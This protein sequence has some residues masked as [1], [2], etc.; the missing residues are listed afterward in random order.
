MRFGLRKLT[1]LDYPGCVAATVFTCGCNFRC[2]FCHNGSL[3]LGS[4]EN[5]EFEREELLDFLQKRRKVL[6]GVCFTGGEPLLHTETLDI[7]AA[8]KSL[9]YRIKL[10]TNG[11]LPGRL[12][13]AVSEGLVD[14]VAMD[15]KNS[16]GKYELTSGN[17]AVLDQ[18]CESV[19]FLLNSSIDYEFRTTV[20]KP[21]HCREDFQAIGGWLRGA[22][23]YFLQKFAP[24]PDILSADMDMEAPSQDEMQ[25]FLAEVQKFIP[26]A[27]IRGE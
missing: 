24:A 27:G 21:L 2:P 15:I 7:L 11:S 18:V 25:E 5:L 9:G 10:D 12:K 1:L 13:M 17:G 14:T 19:E 6:D 26:N 3:V 20:V 4:D 22:K 8:A 23:R 16:P